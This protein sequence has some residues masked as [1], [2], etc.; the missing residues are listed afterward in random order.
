[1]IT[2]WRLDTAQESVGLPSDA[3]N[4]LLDYAI[5]I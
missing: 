2:K 3:T 1:M 4:A 5:E